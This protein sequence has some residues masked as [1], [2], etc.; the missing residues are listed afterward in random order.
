MASKNSI[1]ASPSTVRR[2]GA[3]AERL[4]VDVT[5]SSVS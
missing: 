2:P 3:A 4:A 1:I 5:I